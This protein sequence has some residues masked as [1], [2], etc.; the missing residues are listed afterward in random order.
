MNIVFNVFADNSKGRFAWMIRKREQEEVGSCKHAR[1]FLT[2]TKAM[3][4]RL[5]LHV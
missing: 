2:L 1:C 5:T 3:L 4:K